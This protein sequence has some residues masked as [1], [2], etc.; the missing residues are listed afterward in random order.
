MTDTEEIDLSE[1]GMPVLSMDIK[2]TLVFASDTEGTATAEV[3]KWNGQWPDELKEK[4]QTGM[5]EDNGAFTC[6]YNAEAKTG[7][8]T[9]KSGTK[10]TCTVDVDKREL[11]TT[12]PDEDGEMVTTV[13]KLQ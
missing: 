12:E 8:Y 10:G 3:T 6:I 4:V 11:T 2:V 5:D 7:T 9:L 13:F 1:M